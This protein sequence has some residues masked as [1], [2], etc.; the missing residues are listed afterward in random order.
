MLRLFVGINQSFVNTPDDDSHM[1]GSIISTIKKDFHN[2][3][4][5]EMD[6][7]RPHALLP[8]LSIRALPCVVVPYVL[9][10]LSLY[11]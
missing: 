2:A 8:S 11:I 4:M 6:A 5:M 1:S 10:F 9:V 7:G 3:W